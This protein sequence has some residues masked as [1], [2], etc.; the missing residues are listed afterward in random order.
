[1]SN[2]TLSILL[3]IFAFLAAISGVVQALTG[4]GWLQVPIAHGRLAE[5]AFVILVLASIFAWI[6]SRRGGGKGLLMHAAGM[7]VFALV[8]IAVGHMG[9]RTVHIVLGVLFLLGVLALATL[10]LRARETSL[11]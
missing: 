11:P 6:W 7:A 9:M 1:M 10:S 2:S 4:F 8:Q 3:K 5:A